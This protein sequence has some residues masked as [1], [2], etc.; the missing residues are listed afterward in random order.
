MGTFALALAFAGNDLVNL[1]VFPSQ[2]SPRF[3]DYTANGEGNPNG[4]LM[5]S[6]LG[7]AK[8]PWYFLIGAGAV[9]VYALCTSEKSTRRN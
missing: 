8:T 2:V 3:L 9:M 7:P 1:L 4:F 6:L 5:T